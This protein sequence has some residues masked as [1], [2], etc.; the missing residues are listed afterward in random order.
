VSITRRQPPTASAGSAGSWNASGCHQ[1]LSAKCMRRS[2]DRL[3]AVIARLR[4]SS[5]RSGWAQVH[6]VQLHVTR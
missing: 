4:E 1:A 3:V 6:A 5:A 2:P